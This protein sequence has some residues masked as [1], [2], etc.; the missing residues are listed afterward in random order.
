MKYTLSRL[1]RSKEFWGVLIIICGFFVLRLPSLIEPYWYGDEGIYQIIGRA[2]RHGRILYSGIWDNKP[3]LLY[4]IYAAFDGNQFWI[5][6]FSLFI[7]I[8]TLLA[9]FFLVRKLF[10]KQTRSLILTGIFGLCLATPLLEGNIANAENF[11]LL[12]IILAAFLLYRETE[13]RHTDVRFLFISGLLIGMAFITKIVAV[14]DLTAFFVF[15]FLLFMQGRTFQKKL[16]SQLGDFTKISAV[17][18]LGFLIPFILCCLYFI[19]VHAFYP[20]FTAVFSSNIGYVG[21]GN[22]FLIPQGLLIIK[23]IFLLGFC[24]LLLRFRDKITKPT[25]FILTW[26]AFSLFNAFFSERPYTHYVLVLLPSLILFIGWVFTASTNYAKT[27][28]VVLG[29]ILLAIILH[30]FQI[31]SIKRIASYYNNYLS[32]VSG[33]KSITA[34]RSY[35][36]PGTPGTYNL[37]L[38]VKSNTKPPDAIFVWGN[39]AQIYVLSDKLPPGRFTVAYHVLGNSKNIKETA[40]AVQRA[41]P[42]FII[43]L[44]NIPPLPFSVNGYQVKFNTDNALIYERVY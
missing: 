34:Y 15:A 28:R 35:F 20:F 26:L 4:L 30:S 11:M 19:A 3:P 16:L 27:V 14:F 38:F 32:F 36:D 39:N 31:Y 17:Y 41:Q 7:G 12:P 42:K 1:E 6:V 23:L 5:R 10:K 24:L 9:F 29:V 37:S 21:Y 22:T 13:K 2:L 43:A 44:N 8:L 33:R 40:Q 25:L 18:L